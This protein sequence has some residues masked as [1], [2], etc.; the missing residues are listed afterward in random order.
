MPKDKCPICGEV[1]ESSFY[2][3]TV[4]VEN[5]IHHLAICKTCGY[6]EKP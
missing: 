3:R 6:E 2:H 4:T 1:D 5:K